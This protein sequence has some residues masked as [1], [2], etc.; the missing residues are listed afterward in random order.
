MQQRIRE[1]GLNLLE[2]NGAMMRDS[3][4]KSKRIGLC[5]ASLAVLFGIFGRCAF[6]QA[7]TTSGEFWVEPPTLVSLGFEWKIEG[8]DNRNAKVEVTYRKKGEQQWHKALPLLR[9]HGEISGRGAGAATLATDFESV[10]PGRVAGPADTGSAN[11]ARGN[12]QPV[13]AFTY[14]APNMFSGSI[15]NLE[16]DTEYECRFVLTDRDGVKGEATKLVT[17]RTRKAPEPTPGGHIYHVYPIGY[18]GQ[19]QEP[20]FTGLFAAYYTGCHTSDFEDAFPPRVRPGDTILVHAGLYLGDRYTYTSA[21]DAPGTATGKLALCTVFDGTYYLTA[22]GTPDKPI[23]IKAAGDGEVIFDGDG[24][25]TLFNVMAA[26]YNVFEGIT[27]RNTNVAFLT[28]IKYIAG[29]SGFGLIGSKVYDVGRA[30]EDDWAGSKNYYIADNVLIGRHTPARMMG[31]T[32]VWAKIP[33][34]PEVLGGN[35]GSE[36]AVKVYGQGHVVAYNYV[37]NWHDGIDVATYGNPDGTP[38][39]GTVGEI[40]DH[41]PLSIDFYNNY[42]FN[43][44]D[45]CIETDGGA[46]NIRVFKNLCFNSA[47]GAL[48]SEPTEGG[49]IY[50]VQN[51]VY[52]TARGS[53][54]K[55]VYTPTGILTYSNTF[56]GDTH[57]GASSNQ[58]FADNLILGEDTHTTIFSVNTFTNYSTSDYNAFRPNAGSDNAFEWNSPSFDVQMDYKNALTRRPFKTLAE[59]S[60]AT[61]QDKHSVLVDYN[62][63]M[64]AKMPDQSDITR[65]YFPKSFDFRLKTGSAASGVGIPLPTI[66]DGYTGKAPDLG[67]YQTGVP[68]PHYG[69]RN[70]MMEKLA[71]ADNPAAAE[72]ASYMT[73]PEAGQAAVAPPRESTNSAAPQ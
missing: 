21:G 4:S 22:S 51:L 66:T 34:Y 23:F 6:A 38:R 58:D 30:V 62:V 8:D 1:I 3:W 26:N 65:L 31:W 35:F 10:N 46:R 55:Y 32:P 5:A 25:Q 14:V 64:N 11:P 9:L 71:Q 63:F 17:A 15:L 2:R 18:K 61:G 57:S 13:Q 29:S 60:Q 68:L 33:G 70:Q 41:V 45:N 12:P 37:A 54:T 28:G 43:M 36:Y 39:D 7:G 52:N 19:K 40:R 49:P 44:G 47:G 48:S 27:V 16:P 59:Y 67:A 69:P 72:E 24:A 73:P 20:S 50:F 56:I 53:A 42:I